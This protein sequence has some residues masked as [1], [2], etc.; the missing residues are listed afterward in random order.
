MVTTD[1]QFGVLGPL[2]LSGD[3][4]VEYVDAGDAS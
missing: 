3:R 4:L 1:L 2:H